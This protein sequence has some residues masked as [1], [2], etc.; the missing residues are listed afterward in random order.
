MIRTASFEDALFEEYNATRLVHYF[1]MEFKHNVVG[2]MGK[3]KTR[4]L[5]HCIGWVSSYETQ[6]SE[7]MSVGLPKMARGIRNAQTLES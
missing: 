5:A 1:Q 7:A 3:H 4:P 6:H 2:Y